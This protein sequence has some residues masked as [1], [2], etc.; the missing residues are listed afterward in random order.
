MQT[1][2]L[3]KTPMAINSIYQSASVIEFQK[4][5]DSTTKTL[6][7]IDVEPYAPRIVCATDDTEYTAVTIDKNG[8]VYAATTTGKSVALTKTPYATPESAALTQV[9]EMWV[10]SRYHFYADEDTVFVDEETGEQVPINSDDIED[11]LTV[12]ATLTMR[13]RYTTVTVR[14]I[15]ERSYNINGYET[16]YSGAPYDAEDALDFIFKWYG[17]C[18]RHTITRP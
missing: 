2:I 4:R 3:F 14:R 8:T 17:T 18:T 7:R 5:Y 13:D 12:G 10:G 15:D 1:T 11:N 6:V 9:G 16:D